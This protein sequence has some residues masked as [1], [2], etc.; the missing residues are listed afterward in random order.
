M[1][2]LVLLGMMIASGIIMPSSNPAF[3]QDQPQFILGFKT[4]AGMIHN[5][6]GQPLEDEHF[7][8]QT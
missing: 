2:W 3:A 1:R 5:I 7:D 6:V 8:P 4:L